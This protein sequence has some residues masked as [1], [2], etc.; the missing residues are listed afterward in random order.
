VPLNKPPE[1]AANT[2]ETRYRKPTGGAVN[3]KR[4]ATQVIAATPRREPQAKMSRSSLYFS[5]GDRF[6]PELERTFCASGVER[7]SEIGKAVIPLALITTASIEPQS[8]SHKVE[9][10]DNPSRVVNSIQTVNRL[11]DKI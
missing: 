7:D 11:R 10:G 8:S 1:A 3:P 6:V 5:P 9:D 4:D 2:T